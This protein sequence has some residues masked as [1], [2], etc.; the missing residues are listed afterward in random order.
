MCSVNKYLTKQEEE[1]SF[2]EISK[3]ITIAQEQFKIKNLVLT[4][5]E[6]LLLVDLITQTSAFAKQAGMKVILTTNGFYL[7]EHA[8]RLAHSGVSHF[9]ISIDGLENTH[10]YIRKNSLSFAKAVQGIEILTDLRQKNN[11]KY[12]IGIGMVIL[13]PNIPEL[14]DLF[15][16]ADSLGVDN[17]D[18]LP[19][20]P[21]N[22][23]FSNTENTALWPNESS[24]NLFLQLYEKIA[25]SKTRHI[26]INNLID[27]DLIAKYYTRKMRKRD[28]QCMAGFKNIF[29]TMSDPKQLGRFEPCVFMCKAHIPLRDQNYNLKKAWYSAQARWARKDIKRCNV[30]CYQPC[31]SFPSLLKLLKLR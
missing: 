19:Y 24:V 28:W 26:R 4:G 17:M 14:Y 1:M 8:Q 25:Q 27:A 18:I 11:L 5:G 2:N 23:D 21:D 29:I 13:K 15:I 16:Q 3:I 30:Y 20:L 12:S 22:T 10:N 6:P 7:K 31:F 9:H